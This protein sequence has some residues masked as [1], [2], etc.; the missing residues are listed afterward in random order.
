MLCRLSWELGELCDGVSVPEG[1][2]ESGGGNF[3]TA[4]LER[5]V[6]RVMSKKAWVKGSYVVE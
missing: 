1:L 5:V 2:G 4:G 6:G 3:Y